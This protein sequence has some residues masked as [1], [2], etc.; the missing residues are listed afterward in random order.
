MESMLDQ[1]SRLTAAEQ[2]QLVE[3]NDTH[4]PLN[5]EKCIHQLFEETSKI[6]KVEGTFHGDLES[7]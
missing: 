6:G 4:T 7:K 1:R 3:W 2:Q 5:D